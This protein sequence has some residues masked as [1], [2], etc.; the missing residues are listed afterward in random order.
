MKQAKSPFSGMVL[1]GFCKQMSILLT[2]AIPIYEGLQVMAEDASSEAEKKLLTAMSD[3]VRLGSSLSQAVKDSGS[4]PSYMEEMTQLGERTGTLDTTM[5]GLAD[6]YE[7]ETRMAENLKRA[8][9]YPAMMIFMLLLIL[10]VLF[11]KVM[12]VFSGVYEQLGASIPPVTQ[13]AIRLGG[14]LSGLAL[15][16]TVILVL[17][18]V[19]F[20]LTGTNEKSA[21][22]FAS[23]MNAFR[24]RSKISKM[25]AIRRFCSTMSVTLRCGLRVEEGLEMAS[26]M[27]GQRQVSEAV[28]KCRDMI[29]SGSDFYESVREAGLF[30]GFDL[31]LIRVSSRAGRLEQTLGELSADYDQKASDALDSMTARLEPVIVSVLAVAVGLVLLFVMLPLVGILS[32]IG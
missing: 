15:A 3:Q 4:F 14:V 24:S 22:V 10:F 27:A 28:L 25:T 12:P 20:R 8:L 29:S 6:F 13:T 2:S 5:E 1:A 26:R 9:T 30:S 17:A 31:Q 32:A 19:F 23:I 16:V 18:F 21:A 7:R 11:V